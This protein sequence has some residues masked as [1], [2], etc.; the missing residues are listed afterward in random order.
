MRTSFG[1]FSTAST[2][3]PAAAA[4]TASPAT[5]DSDPSAENDTPDGRSATLRY[6]P[7]PFGELQVR[8]RLPT[9]AVCVSASSTVRS[10]APSST[11]LR[12]SALVDP[13]VSTTS[14]F[15]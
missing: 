5:T 12:R 6:S 11:A 4:R 14:I 2:P 3:R 1:H 9:P 8:A 15:A 13:V 10:A 7:A